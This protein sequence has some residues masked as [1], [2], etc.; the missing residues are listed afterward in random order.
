MYG[1]QLRRNARLDRADLWSDVRPGSLYGALHRL[2]AEGLIE[3]LRTEQAGNLPARTVYAITS[4]GLRELKTLRAEALAEVGLRP[5]PVDLA[6][7][8]SADLD[9]DTLRGFIEDR[10]KV[11]TAQTAQYGHLAE[12]AWPEQTVAD[13]L[14][15]EHTRL[16]LEAE[17]T[18]HRLLLDR[19]GKLTAESEH[20]ASSTGR[21]DRL[22]KLAA[23]SEQASRQE[24]ALDRP[25]AASGAGSAGTMA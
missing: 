24:T 7:A 2:A 21:L 6:L 10:I 20:A 18:W 5:D 3:P 11:L 14:V 17:L 25:A 15:A 22:G 23:E 9:E 19:L 13:D 1:H 16:R 8:M 12:R 4:E